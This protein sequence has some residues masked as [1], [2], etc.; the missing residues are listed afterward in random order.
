M[1]SFILVTPSVI[2]ELQIESHLN[3]VFMRW[4][5]KKFLRK[6][7]ITS[8]LIFQVSSLFIDKLRWKNLA[9]VDAG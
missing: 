1:N 3:N 5:M 2:I 9:R 4:S 6:A 8:S 7:S